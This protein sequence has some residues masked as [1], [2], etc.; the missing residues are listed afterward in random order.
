[1]YYIYLYIYVKFVR[2]TL[3]PFRNRRRKKKKEM[4]KKK[5]NMQ[6]CAL[7]KTEIKGLAKIPLGEGS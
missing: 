5:K 6:V 2:E 4:K 7:K 3:Y 1:M